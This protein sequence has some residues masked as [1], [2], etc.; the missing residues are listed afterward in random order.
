MDDLKNLARLLKVFHAA[1]SKKDK[2]FNGVS[3]E[4]FIIQMQW[5]LISYSS[6]YASW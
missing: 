1:S 4:Y 2:F 5:I 3:R 6:Y